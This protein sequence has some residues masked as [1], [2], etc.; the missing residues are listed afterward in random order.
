MTEP[1]KKT[2]SAHLFQSEKL[3]VTLNS[4]PLVSKASN[5]KEVNVI[6][7]FSRRYFLMKMSAPTVRL[8]TAI[9]ILGR[10]H[11]DS[12]IS[13]KKPHTAMLMPSIGL[14]K[15]FIDVLSKA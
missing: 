8:S 13:P 14:I 10:C 3:F 2:P 12:E 7:S 1:N 4:A 9:A 5:Q 11:S 15:R 6:L